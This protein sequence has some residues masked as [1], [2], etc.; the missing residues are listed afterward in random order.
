MSQWFYIRQWKQ[1]AWE[2]LLEYRTIRV[3][4]QTDNLSQRET[5]PK[6]VKLPLD[7]E[8]TNEGICKYLTDKYGWCVYDWSVADGDINET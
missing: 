8:L 4:W 5:L 6:L 3:K 7:V 2:R 1:K